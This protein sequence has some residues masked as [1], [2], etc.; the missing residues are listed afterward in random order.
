MLTGYVTA[1][2]YNNTLV[3]HY[4]YYYYYYVLRLLLIIHSVL[5][6]M[7]PA[8]IPNCALRRTHVCWRGEG[9]ALFSE[10]KVV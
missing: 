2:V 8:C 10:H 1:H 7:L 6:F 3:K 4:Y 5:N 9:E